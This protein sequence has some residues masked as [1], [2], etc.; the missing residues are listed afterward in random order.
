M[1]EFLLTQHQYRPPASVAMFT[2]TFDAHHDIAEPKNA[3]RRTMDVLYNDGV[4]VAGGTITNMSVATTAVPPS[5]VL[6]QHNIWDEATFP[7]FE[8]ASTANAISECGAKGDGV[9]DDHPALMECL[10]KHADVFL[11][12]GYYRLSNTLELNPVSSF[13]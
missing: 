6:A 8:A 7:N 5:D 9:T 11:P 13:N 3:D 1:C 4:R 2:S 10:R 12:K